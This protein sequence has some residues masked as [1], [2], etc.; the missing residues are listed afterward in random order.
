MPQMTQKSEVTLATL[1][2]T[3]PKEKRGTNWG[4]VVI[5]AIIV[6]GVLLVV[7]AEI[8]LA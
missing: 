2:E 3:E 8:L 6:I 7:W 5:A 1:M 4:L